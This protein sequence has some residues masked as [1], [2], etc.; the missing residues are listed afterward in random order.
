M[1]YHKLGKGMSAGPDTAPLGDMEKNFRAAFLSLAGEERSL[2]AAF[3]GGPDS[4][5]LLH[6]CLRLAGDLGLNLFAA[7]LDH[8]LRGELGER[9]RRAAEAEATRAGIPFFWEKADCRALAAERSLSLEEAGRRARYD[10]LERARV[11]TGA[12]LIATGHTADDQAETVLFNLLR[13][14]GPR[15]LA[16]I[17]RRRGRVIR[18]LLGFWRRDLL[19]YL[20]GR[21]LGYVEDE[22]NRDLDFTRNRL[23]RHLL[24]LLERDYNPAVKAALVRTAEVLREEEKVWE[25]WT[26]RARA[27]VDWR[28][29]EGRIGLDRAGLAGLSRALARRLVR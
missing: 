20:K 13:G 23:R 7:H 26:A 19:A 15:G 17:P 10:F 4:T 9:D 5:A 3:S 2:V 25:D 16:G 28:S 1:N 18:P 24:P 21:G 11:Q 29:E 27:Q 12:G 6:L 22:T 8:G 14:A